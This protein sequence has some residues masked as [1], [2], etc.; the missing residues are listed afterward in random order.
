MEI[1]LTRHFDRYERNT[2]AG[3]AE[4]AAMFRDA[5]ALLSAVD[6]IKPE[7]HVALNRLASKLLKEGSSPR[8]AVPV[9]VL[10]M[11][12]QHYLGNLHSHV[13]L[14]WCAQNLDRHSPDRAYVSALRAHYKSA[15]CAYSQKFALF[16]LRHLIRCRN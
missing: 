8:K 10:A 3:L 13:F 2:E 12:N 9:V 11:L 15:Q 6:G 16:F 7:L 14:L 5:D 4:I 1:N